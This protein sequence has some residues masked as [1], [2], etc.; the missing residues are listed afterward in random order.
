MR[1]QA[2]INEKGTGFKGFIPAVFRRLVSETFNGL[3]ENEAV[4]KVTA[5]PDLVRNRKARP[6]AWEKEVIEASCCVRI[7]R[8]VSLL[9]PMSRLMAAP[10]TASPFPNITRN[11]AS[12]ATAP[13]RANLTLR[14]IQRKGE[15]S[16]TSAGLSA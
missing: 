1:I 13:Q 10:P 6:D 5:P 16:V 11:P 14:D 15:S 12:P 8:K 2:T 9:R 4:I 7:G 3:A